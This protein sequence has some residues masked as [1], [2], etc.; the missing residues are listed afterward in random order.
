[1]DV[2]VAARVSILAVVVYGGG[3]GLRADVPFVR[4]DVNDDGLVNVADAVAAL[5]FLSPSALRLRVRRP[6][7]PMTTLGSTSPM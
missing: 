5:D 3:G 2:K 6:W 4:G 7:T 1:M